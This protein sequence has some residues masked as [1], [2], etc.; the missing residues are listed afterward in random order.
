[1]AALRAEAMLDSKTVFT[2]N[3]VSYLSNSGT[4]GPKCI[5]YEPDI[6]SSIL[7]NRLP[8]MGSADGGNSGG[9]AEIASAR[10]IGLRAVKS[11]LI[12]WVSIPT[13]S[14]FERRA[15]EIGLMTICIPRS[16]VPIA[17]FSIL[18]YLSFLP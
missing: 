18:H 12:F 2:L 10:A 7:Y 17:T 6:I 13:V 4:D 11:E 14:S 16:L 1:M 15:L 5:P 8:V 9:S 3:S